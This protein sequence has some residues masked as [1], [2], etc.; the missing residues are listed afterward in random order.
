MGNHHATGHAFNFCGCTDVFGFEGSAKAVIHMYD[1]QP[2]NARSLIRDR[3][4][5]QG[6]LARTSPL[7]KVPVKD[8]LSYFRQKVTSSWVR[9]SSEVQKDEFVETIIML[10]GHLDIPHNPREREGL[11]EV[12]DSM[13]FDGNGTL[14]TGEWA[15]GLSVYMKGSMEEAVRAVFNCLDANGDGAI[16]KS[17]LQVYLSPFVKAMSPPEAAALRPLLEKKAVDDIYYDMDMDHTADISSDEMLSW[18]KR[19]NNIVDRLADII[20]QEVYQIWLTESKKKVTNM[21][22][23][24]DSPGSPHSGVYNPQDGDMPGSM[25]SMNGTQSSA[26]HGGSPMSH[27]E[28]GPPPHST[29]PQGQ[30]NGW[31]GGYFNGNQPSPASR[32]PMSSPPPASAPVNVHDPFHD[33][34]AIPR[35]GAVPPPPPPPAPG[36]AVPVGVAGVHPQPAGF[37]PPQAYHT[38][39][40]GFPSPCR[41]SPQYTGAY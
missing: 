14:S 6:D 3:L 37:P 36:R 41:S 33:P 13:D 16:S 38:S 10:L 20:D 35:Q 32:S 31:F 5:K 25:R 24:Y 18:S 39:H 29:S 30:K 34:F 22:R 12:F 27:S 4:N 26:G 9:P 1:I 21:R 17:E 8:G 2:W 28:Y 11:Y 19:G 7:R 15:A 40:Y 23:S